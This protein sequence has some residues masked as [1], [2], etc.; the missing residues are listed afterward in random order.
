M[1][2][3]VLQPAYS[4]QQHLLCSSG[5]L[6]LNLMVIQE[7]AFLCKAFPT[8][9]WVE[10]GANPYHIGYF[11]SFTRFAEVCTSPGRVQSLEFLT[12]YMSGESFRV[13]LLSLK[14]S[15]K[16]ALV[17]RFSFQTF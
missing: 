14:L 3:S 5:Q 15:L 7:L 2:N 17:Y 16:I 10:V 1:T 9:L 13:C 6:L 4:Q 11:R 12:S 8:V